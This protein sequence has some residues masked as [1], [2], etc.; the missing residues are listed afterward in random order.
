MDTNTRE[1]NEQASVET[2]FAWSWQRALALGAA[3][4]AVTAGLGLATAQGEESSNRF[5]WSE[6]GSHMM[7]MAGWRHGDDGERGGGWGRHGGGMGMGMGGMMRVMDEIDATPEQQKKLFAIFDGVRGEM[8]DTMID[9]R[10]TR[11]EVMELLSA[12]QIDR[13]AA[14]KL[15][16][17]RV[18]AMDEASKTMTNALIE[19]A[20]VLTPEQRTKLAELIEERGMRH[21]RGRW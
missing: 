17:E 7:Q 20:E 12:P 2:G 21:G 8:R 5:G 14:E 18:A 13:A 1:R 11:G 4:V 3:V 15:R 19:A 10:S 6:R 9:F 16:A